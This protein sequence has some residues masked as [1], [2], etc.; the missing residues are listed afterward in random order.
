MRTQRV[1]YLADTNLLLRWV[2]TSDPMHQTAVRAVVTLQQR[3]D[4]THVT[5]QNLIEYWNV[6]TRPLAR[7]GFG[8]T[9]HDANREITRI[10]S[11]F[12]LAPD[13][14][15]IYPE[16]RRLVTAAGV[17]GVQVH[18]ARLAAVMRVHRLTHILTFNTTDFAR[19][20]GISPVHPASL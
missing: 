9:P 1:D 8:F 20:P 7:N 2:K 4:R 5:P 15:G 12:R 18:D 14:L 17:S 11:F 13:T 19:Y 16:W 6:L 3:G 10:E